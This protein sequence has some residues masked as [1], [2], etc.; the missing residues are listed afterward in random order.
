VRRFLLAVLAAAPLLLPNVSIPQRNEEVL[1][2]AVVG[3]TGK[4][5]EEVTA[6]IA[7]VHA[8]TPFDAVVITGD[9]F[10]P[11]GVTSPSDPRWSLIRPLSTLGLP[12]LPVLGNHDSCGAAKPEVQI[13]APL[14]HWLFPARQYTASSSVADLLFLD[15]T[16]FATGKD[17]G[18]VPAAVAQAFA[19]PRGRWRIAVG[20][21]IIVS[22]GW[23]GRFPRKE[24]DRM[25]ELLP[26]LKSDEV[27]LY[28]C[29]H[30]HH[31]ELVDTRPRMLV[32]GAGSD[33]IPPLARRG[34]TLWPDEPQR[35]IGFAVVELT[36][37]R[38]TVRFYGKKGKPLS[39]DFTFLKS[40]E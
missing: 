23:H 19:R 5:A 20:H 38:M 25:L 13:Q 7:A 10:Y 34:K 2:I 28:I 17:H 18:S 3:D 39:R 22:S 31:L 11:C 14:P 33:P 40:A 27:D 37:S 35:T 29:G 6:S 12:L 21:H 9:N 4:G 26:K 16:P 36:A 24:H 32:S 15:T 30:D 8:Q 1:R